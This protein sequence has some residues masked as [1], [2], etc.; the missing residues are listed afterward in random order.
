MD[1]F[2]ILSRERGTLLEIYSSGDLAEK[3]VAVLTRVVIL[4]VTF[5]VTGSITFN[6]VL[7]LF[8]LIKGCLSRWHAKRSWGEVREISSESC[9]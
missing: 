7:S 4:G 8:T 1:S 6:V 3:V 9:M 2:Y 5:T